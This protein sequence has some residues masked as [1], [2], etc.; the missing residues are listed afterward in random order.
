MFSEIEITTEMSSTL[1]KSSKMA[2]IFFGKF[3]FLRF[4]VVFFIY[5][6]VISYIFTTTFSSF[7]LIM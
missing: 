6:F 1:K 7:C 3:Y 5:Q 4:S 2:M